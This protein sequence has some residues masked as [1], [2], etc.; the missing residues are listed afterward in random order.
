MTTTIQ[1]PICEL[2]NCEKREDICNDQVHFICGRCGKFKLTGSL[3]ASIQNYIQSADDRWKLSYW[4]RSNESDNQEQALNSLTIKAILERKLPSLTEQ[5]DLLLKWL[6]SKSSDHGAAVEAYKNL[7]FVV[8][9]AKSAESFVYVTEALKERGLLKETSRPTIMIGRRD[10]EKATF[11]EVGM[12]LTVT[13]NGWEHL[14]KISNAAKSY[15]RAFM[16]MK[17]GDQELDTI[18]SEHFKPAAEQAG[19]TLLRLD[20]NPIAGLI[21]NRMRVEIRSA[22]FVIADLSHDN[23]GAY[24]EAGYAEGLGK[25]VIYTCKK[26]K[27][28]EKSTHFDTNHHLTI[29]WDAGDP[30]KAAEE[31]KATIRATLPHL[32]KLE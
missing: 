12:L 8:I 14:N 6:A 3:D 19:F 22:D 11:N 18:V 4:L 2:D 30:F 9:G 5:F 1:C 7:D 16:A 25:P 26:E 23:L 15:H 31:L 32:A 10:R 13:F 29:Q 28:A 21:D 20:D 17:F 24:W 27:F